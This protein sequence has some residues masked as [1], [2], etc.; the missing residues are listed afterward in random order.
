MEVYVDNMLAK[1]IR[2]TSHI[3]NLSEAFDMLR[4]YRK[5]LNPSKCTFGMSSGK[6]LGF[7]VSRRRIK[8]N[9]E[10]IKVVSEMQAP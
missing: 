3:T 6:F 8:A 4:S 5:K 10:K 9:P 1:S 7:I 2:A